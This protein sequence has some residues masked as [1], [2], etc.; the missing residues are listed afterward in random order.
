MK[1][2]II[3]Y[4]KRNRISTTEVA[5]CL[6]KT[7]NIENSFFVNKGHFSVG[8]MCYIYASGGTNWDVHEQIQ[9]VHDGD[10]VFVDVLDNLDKAVFGDLVCKY[11]I[12][13]RQVS[14]IITNGLLRDA[15]KLIK[16]NWPIWC[17]GYNPVGYVNHQISVPQDILSRIEERKD[18]YK[19]AI[20]VSDDTGVVVI[21]KKFL[22]Q[23]FLNKL[24]FIE[25]QED[26]W[27]DCIDR[28]NFSTFETVCLRK[29]LEK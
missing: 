4:I 14:A 24:V 22:N 12:L 21:T 10:V 9:N 1:E 26:I 18:Y 16:E 23:E 15:P 8:P 6:D 3:D 13:Y 7:G 27:L 29:Y 28:R 5:D 20:V 11:L 17:G 2:Q 19:D 25:E